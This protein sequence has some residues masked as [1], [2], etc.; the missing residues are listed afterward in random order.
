MGIQCTIYTMCALVA[1]DRNCSICVAEGHFIS[2]VNQNHIFVFL[3]WFLQQK[4]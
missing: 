4:C 1:Y 3:G 2:V